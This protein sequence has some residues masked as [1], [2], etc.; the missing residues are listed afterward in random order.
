VALLFGVLLSAGKSGIRHIS[1]RT[2]LGQLYLA[3]VMSGIIYNYT[4]AAF[5]VNH[6]VGFCVWLAAVQYTPVQELAWSKENEE[7]SV[8]PHPPMQNAAINNECA[9]STSPA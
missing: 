3:L 2:G 6:I 7:I 1:T 5:N 9:R 8:S 4:E